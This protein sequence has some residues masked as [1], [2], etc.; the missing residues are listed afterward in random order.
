MN[1][2]CDRYSTWL[3][4]MSGLVII[5]TS[6]AGILLFAKVGGFEIDKKWYV[7]LYIMYTLNIILAIALLLLPTK[8]YLCG[9]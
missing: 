5:F 3:A 1:Y 2:I 6:I 7:W 8:E 4:S 9:G